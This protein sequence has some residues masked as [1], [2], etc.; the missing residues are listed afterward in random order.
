[1]T[2][3]LPGPIRIYADPD[4]LSQLY[5]NLLTN[6]ANYTDNYGQL[7]ITISREADK[8]VL[9]FS[10]SEPGVPELE[11]PRL[12]DRFY[13]VESSRNRHH[14]GAGLGLALCSNI[15]EAHHGLIQAHTSPLKGLAIRIELPMSA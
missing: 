4:R 5:R 15:V 1:L 2:N 9:N 14:G 6:S 11:L 12:F 8:L 7:D 10:D 13:R 3:N